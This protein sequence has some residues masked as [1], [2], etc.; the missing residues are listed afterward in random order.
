M[1]DHG[2]QNSGQAVKT[3]TG[4]GEDPKFESTRTSTSWGGVGFVTPLDR[5]TM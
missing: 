3:E 2:S 5:V 1:A 4:Q